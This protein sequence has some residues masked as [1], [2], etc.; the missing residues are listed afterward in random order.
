MSSRDSRTVLKQYNLSLDLDTRL[1]ICTAPS[2]GFALSPKYANITSHLRDKHQI[3]QGYH[4]EVTRCLH[5][6][7][8]EG[9][10]HPADA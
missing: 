3:T 4:S 9:I 2:C 8:L 5:E 6:L 1:L 7:Y 10:Y